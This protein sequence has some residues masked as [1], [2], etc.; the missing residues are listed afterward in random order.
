MSSPEPQNRALAPLAA[1]L[2]LD[3]R[4][5]ELAP[6]S[7]RMRLFEPAP[8]QLEGQTDMLAA[9]AALDDQTELEPS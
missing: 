7:E 2:D 4:A 8:A 6:Q 3:G 5:H 1:Q 9:L